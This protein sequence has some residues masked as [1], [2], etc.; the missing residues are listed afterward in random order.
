MIKWLWL[1]LIPSLVFAEKPASIN[2][3]KD[4]F[5]LGIAAQHIVIYPEATTITELELNK[6]DNGFEQLLSQ[7]D[8][9]KDSR[10]FLLFLQPGS[11]RLHRRIRHMIEERGFD[12]GFDPVGVGSN[13][14]PTFYEDLPP[15]G[16]EKIG[17][18]AFVR[19]R[20]YQTSKAP[21]DVEVRSDS[22]MIV[23]N[24][25]EVPRDELHI[26]GN[27]LLQWVEQ[28]VTHNKYPTDVCNDSGSDEF[29]T[30]VLETVYHACPEGIWVTKLGTPLEVPT[31]GRT[32][33]Y[34]LCQSNQLF[35]VIDDGP[36]EPI[37]IPE[38]LTTSPD[39]Q[40]ICF[41]VRPDSFV[42]FRKARK[43]AWA[44]G[45]DI[46]CELQ[47]ES[48]PLAI[49]SDGHLLFPERTTK[50]NR[51]FEQSV[52]GYAAQGASSPEP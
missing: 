27:A 28:C 49:G 1:I 37:D 25:I 9:L 19:G 46:S 21:C 20:K 36:S 26:P 29:Y 45:I 32:P 35:E 50:H 52:P 17:M 15:S 8:K 38:L 13:C 33:V 34:I 2:L 43:E 5:G 30:E 10:Y 39:S 42:I 44:H 4:V 41:L 12:V 16:I 24:Q 3:I 51:D 23:T 48:G 11:A 31:N 40:Y 18:D 6:P 14:S 47:D 22:V 7:A